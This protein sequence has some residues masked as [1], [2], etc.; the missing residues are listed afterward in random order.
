[1]FKMALQLMDKDKGDK[2]NA[3]LRTALLKA[4]VDSAE[5]QANIIQEQA[6]AAAVGARAKLLTKMIVSGVL[7]RE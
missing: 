6:K 7:S 5:G 4:Q 2:D 1:M 3:E